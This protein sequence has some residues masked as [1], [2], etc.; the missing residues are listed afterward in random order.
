MRWANRKR[1]IWALFEQIH[2]MCRKSHRNLLTL[3]VDTT[4]M[5]PTESNKLQLAKGFL[6]GAPSGV[7]QRGLELPATLGS[8]LCGITQ[9]LWALVSHP[10]D[11]PLQMIDSAVESLEYAKSHDI[12]AISK[13]VTPELH[14][15][16]QKWDHLSPEA[17]GKELGVLIGKY[18]VD[19]LT[20]AGTTKGLECAVKLRRANALYNLKVLSALSESTA[21][22]GVFITAV[23]ELMAERQRFFSSAKIQLDKQG[24]HIKGH[25]N[26]ISDESRSILTH[27]EPD[28]LLKKYGGKGKAYAKLK[29]GKAGYKEVVVCDE[30]IGECVDRV[31]KTSTPTKRAT[32]HYDKDGGAHIVPAPP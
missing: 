26:Y 3:N 31:T 15:L 17:Q 28:L 19:I 5:P 24:K 11:T 1:E 2:E 25:R 23:K 21:G 14:E 4:L 27:P 9:A 13:E 7:F 16:F 6:Q 29:A 12:R 22:Q 8:S 20:V 30:I 18:G 10:I 32:I